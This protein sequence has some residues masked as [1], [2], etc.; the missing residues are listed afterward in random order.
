MQKGSWE[1]YNMTKEQV[2]E[3][4]SGTMGQMGGSTMMA[5]ARKVEI[6]SCSRLGNF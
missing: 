3:A 6:N 1:K 4:T 5:E 2:A